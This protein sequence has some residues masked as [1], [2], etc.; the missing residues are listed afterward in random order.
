MIGEVL[1]IREAAE[2]GFAWLITS[3]AT[4]QSEVEICLPCGFT[5]DDLAPLLDATRWFERLEE[6]WTLRVDRCLADISETLTRMIE[7][8]DSVWEPC[9]PLEEVHRAI[10]K[11]AESMG[12]AAS[13][14][15][16]LSSAFLDVEFCDALADQL[17]SSAADRVIRWTRVNLNQH[18]RPMRREILRRYLATSDGF[19]P[20][21]KSLPLERRSGRRAV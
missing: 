19:A 8:F 15:D 2:D 9:E 20:M 5:A 10:L 21:A 13:G 11:E 1:T 17:R 18:V 12:L 4:K 6:R 14:L 7:M 3:S 16:H